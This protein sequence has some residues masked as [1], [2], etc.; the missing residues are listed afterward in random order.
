MDI[1]SPSKTAEIGERWSNRELLRL[2]GPLIIDQFLTVMLGVIDTLMV[3]V[4]GEAAVSGVYLVDTINVLLINIIFSVTTGGVVICNQYL[5]RRDG[6]SASKAA[7]QLIYGIMILS[8]LFMIITRLFPRPL[9]LLV[10]GQ[11]EPEVLVNAEQYFF[12][13]SMSYPFIALFTA[14]AALFRSMGNSR[15]G[16]WISLLVNILNVAGNALF[17]F[18]LHWGVS[19][20]AFST[21]ISRMVAAVVVMAL[22]YRFRSG[23]IQIRGILRVK[24][25]P[26]IMGKI[27]R[28][29]LPNGM[30]GIMF[31]MGKLFS[32]RLVS[33]FGAAG[34][35]GNAIAGIMLSIGCLPGMGVASAILIVVGQCMGAGDPRDARKYTRKLLGA[36]Y[37]VMGVLNGLMLILMPIS[38]RFYGLSEEGTRIAIQC[39]SIFCTFAILI[40]GPAYCLPYALR[41][42]GDNT[43]TMVV[44]GASMWIFRIGAAYTLALKFGMGVASIWVAMVIDWVVRMIFFVTRWRG[45]KWEKIKLI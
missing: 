18:G 19:G 14:G 2:I 26:D 27:M 34:I 38:L 11:I 43:F 42:A 16:M 39:G 3:V 45:S 28:I 32:I 23:A 5:G 41:A 30:E 29:A 24:I 40:W 6:D 37:V 36:N 44:S 21:L 8:V 20:A 15:I 1:L 31:Q 17:M 9:L 35:A 13:S 7:K 4:L 12:W 22:L 25:L 33:T 10:Y